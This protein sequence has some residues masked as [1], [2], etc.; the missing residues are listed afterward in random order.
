MP[1]PG[2]YAVGMMFLPTSEIRRNHSKGVFGQV[3]VIL[4]FSQDD[5]N[6]HICPF[7]HVL[8]GIEKG[9]CRAVVYKGQLKPNQL[10]KYAYSHL[11]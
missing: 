3:L 1:L 7:S 11:C 2:D 5:V 9:H 6:L 4:A 10:T 8:V